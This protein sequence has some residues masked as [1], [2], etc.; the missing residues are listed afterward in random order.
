[1]TTKPRDFGILAT[2]QQFGLALQ[3]E[4]TVSGALFNPDENRILAWSNDNTYRRMTSACTVETLG[5][6]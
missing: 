2:G 3:H 5:D 4:S 6:C 1:V